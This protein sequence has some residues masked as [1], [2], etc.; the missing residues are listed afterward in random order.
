[1]LCCRLFCQIFYNKNHLAWV[2]AQIQHTLTIAFKKMYIEHIELARS[3]RN[4]TW[5]LTISS[6]TCYQ[7]SYD[8]GWLP[9]LSI[10]DQGPLLQQSAG[11]TTPRQ[12]SAAE[13]STQASTV[14]TSVASHTGQT[15]G[16]SVQIFGVSDD[17]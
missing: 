10:T 4:R 9:P 2:L 15:F 14:S 13:K 1:M 3:G 5:Y 6:L 8:A 7:L 16:V 17:K 11:L 12:I